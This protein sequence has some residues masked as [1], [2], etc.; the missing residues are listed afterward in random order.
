MRCSVESA[1]E[2]VGHSHASWPRRV[3]EERGRPLLFAPQPDAGKARCRRD[4]QGAD[5][6]ALDRP[7]IRLLKERLI[8]ISAMEPQPRG[9]AF[10][11]WLRE[12]FIVFSLETHEAFRNRGEQIDGS[13]VL[14]GETFRLRQSGSQ[15]RQAQP[16]RMLSL[17]SSSKRL[18]GHVVCSS[19]KAA[20][21]P[22][23]RDRLSGDV[24]NLYELRQ[25]VS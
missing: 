3:G 20:S 1:V 12:L 17:G 25:G 22:K 21:L 15:L 4:P 13:S 24:L 16:I 8:G 7:R 11:A 19:A 14:Q 23:L 9:Y 2:G 5:N 6:P 18:R 10:E